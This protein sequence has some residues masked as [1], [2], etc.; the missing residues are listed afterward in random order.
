MSSSYQQKHRNL[1]QAYINAVQFEEETQQLSQ[2]INSSQNF[3]DYSKKIK[4]IDKFLRDLQGLK[5]MP[6]YKIEQ[7]R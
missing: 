1:L 5:Q 3:F 7:T 4:T 2:N 6:F